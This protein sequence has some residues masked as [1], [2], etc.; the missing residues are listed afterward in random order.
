MVDGG[1]QPGGVLDQRGR[2]PAL[3]VDGEEGGGGEAGGAAGPDPVLFGQDQLDAGADGLQDTGPLL[4]VEV[5][6]GALGGRVARV[7]EAGLH[8]DELHAVDGAGHVAL[9]EFGGVGGAQGGELAGR[10][11]AGERVGQGGEPQG[12]AAEEPGVVEYGGAAA[13]AV[14][15]GQRGP[16]LADVVEQGQR[17]PA[18]A[19][20]EHGPGDD[21][22]AALAAGPAHHDHAG[23]R[24]A[25]EVAPAVLLAVAVAAV[26]PAFHCEQVGRAGFHVQQGRGVVEAEGPGGGGRGG[27]RVHS[28]S[29]SSERL[30]SNR[31]A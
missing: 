28:V 21:G 8:A 7:E 22:V 12:E 10:E 29:V 24:A 20:V 6:G 19:G 5:A 2:Q 3:P 26:R 14:R 13:D 25:Q 23:L 4:A 27:G 9:V 15:P 11:G 16:A 18:E 1:T 17:Q 30:E 31:A